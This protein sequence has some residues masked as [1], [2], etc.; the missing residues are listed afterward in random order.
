MSTQATTFRQGHAAVLNASQPTVTCSWHARNFPQES[1]IMRRGNPEMVS[2]T[3]CERCNAIA[4]PTVKA[5]EV[6]IASRSGNHFHYVNLAKRRCSCPDNTFRHSFCYH[7]RI[8]QWA[9]WIKVSVEQVLANIESGKK[10]FGCKFGANCSFC[11]EGKDYH[12]GK[13]SQMNE[14]AT[15]INQQI[16]AA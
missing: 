11:A 9:E 4:F 1:P 15:A 6:R 13:D 7:L 2:H 10:R 12:P 14:F 8:A 16:E 5:D 3:I